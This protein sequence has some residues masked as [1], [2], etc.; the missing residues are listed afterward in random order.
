M[1]YVIYSTTKMNAEINTTHP[2]SYVKTDDNRILN[3]SHIKWVKMMN[4]CLE[5]CVSASGCR[6]HLNT[7]TICKSNNPYS[8][9]KLN[10][11]FIKLERADVKQ[12]ENL[13]VTNITGDF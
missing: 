11:N 12:H 8:Y 10:A 3:E 5:V 13:D 1:Y 7:H 6:L 4:D 9:N 2:N